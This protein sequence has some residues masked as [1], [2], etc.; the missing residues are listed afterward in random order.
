MPP[1]PRLRVASDTI[2]A[3]A[4][5]DDLDAAVRLIQAELGQTE[6]DIAAAFFDDVRTERW[7]VA[8]HAERVT[9]LQAYV[10]FEE[11]FA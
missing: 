10:A 5:H 4:R 9:I 6:G 11:T 8:D 7:A 2:D 3:A 1:D